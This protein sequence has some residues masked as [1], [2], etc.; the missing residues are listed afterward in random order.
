MPPQWRPSWAPAGAA[1]Q[2]H[3]WV[4]L[5]EVK[6]ARVMVEVDGDMAVVAAAELVVR[7]RVVEVM[8]RAAR[9]AEA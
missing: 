1:K 7:V 9:V 2:A 8:G 5:P 3:G 4:A 6:A